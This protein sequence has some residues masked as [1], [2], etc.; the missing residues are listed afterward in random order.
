[1]RWLLLPGILALS[2]C[3]P[4]V[5]PGPVVPE[6]PPDD[7]CGAPGLQGLVGQ[8]RSVLQTM[9]FGVPTRVIEPGMAVTTDYSPTRLNIELDDRGTIIRVTC[10]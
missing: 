8:N 5:D 9:K 3:V 10:G 1:M 6:L 7:A 2:A 4:V